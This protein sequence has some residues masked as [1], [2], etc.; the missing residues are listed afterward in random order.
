MDKIIPNI[1]KPKFPHSYSARWVK[2]LVKSFL[3]CYFGDKKNPIRKLLSFPLATNAAGGVTS[4][5][6]VIIC[7][8]DGVKTNDNVRKNTQGITGMWTQD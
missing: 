1:R 7:H 4:L 6:G 3:N 2:S 5:S 8:D